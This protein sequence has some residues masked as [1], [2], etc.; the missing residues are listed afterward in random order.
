MTIED[1]VV[2]FTQWDGGYVFPVSV[3]EHYRSTGSIQFDSDSVYRF[4]TEPSYV[5]LR[6]NPIYTDSLGLFAKVKDEFVKPSLLF[7]L[8]SD[9]F[10]EYLAFVYDNISWGENVVHN[11]K[12]NKTPDSLPEPWKSFYFKDSTLVETF[13]YLYFQPRRSKWIAGRT[14]QYSKTFPKIKKYK[15][16]MVYLPFPVGN[17]AYI[18]D[19]IDLDTYEYRGNI[20]AVYLMGIEEYKRIS[21]IIANDS[22]GILVKLNPEYKNLTVEIEL[23]GDSKVS[24][25]KPYAVSLAGNSPIPVRWRNT[26][27]P[28]R[29]LAILL[30]T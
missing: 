24:R 10:G 12:R 19:E 26:R 20:D 14:S 25:R 28:H 13:D 7:Y 5:N 27:L 3:F 23:F 2:L 11:F 9:V 4:Y 21:E 29:I 6:F 16:P 30:A 18:F 22:K 8:E 15:A 1:P 17:G